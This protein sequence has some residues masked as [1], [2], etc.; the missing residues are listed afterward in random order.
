MSS[1]GKMSSIPSAVANNSTE[2][3]IHSVRHLACTYEWFIKNSKRNDRVH[4][5][6]NIREFY[7]GL[8]LSESTVNDIERTHFEVYAKK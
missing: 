1:I 7:G 5:F 3:Y 4:P 6:K 8:N 2:M